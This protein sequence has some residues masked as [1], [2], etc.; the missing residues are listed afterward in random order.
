[1]GA[2]IVTAGYQMDL[3]LCHHWKSG[4][5]KISDADFYEYRYH[6]P[7]TAVATAGKSG[8]DQA[9]LLPTERF[10][11]FVERVAAFLRRD[12]TAAQGG[13]ISCS[14]GCCT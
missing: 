1:M 14:G 9:S 13:W 6:G 2:G 12:F 10:A 3:K 8:I 7:C 4:D 11:A 5:I